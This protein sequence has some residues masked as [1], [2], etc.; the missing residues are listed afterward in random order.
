MLYSLLKAKPNNTKISEE[1]K[2]TN[3]NLL[4]TINP[5]VAEKSEFATFYGKMISTSNFENGEKH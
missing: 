1:I 4:N 3:Q 2:I 5:K